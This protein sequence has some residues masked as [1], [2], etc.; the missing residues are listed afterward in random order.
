MKS[1]ITVGLGF[2]D[3]G[4]GTVV[5]AL[6]R[7]YDAKLVIRYNGG[8]QCAHNVVTDDGRHHEFHQFGSGTLVPGCQTLL[9][10]DVLVN[11]LVMF[12]EAKQLEHLGVPNALKRM[13][14]DDRALV[15]TPF[16]RALNRLREYARGEGCHGSCGMGIGET[17]ADA[18]R[19]PHGAL[20][21]GDLL[22]QKIMRE[23]LN[24]TRNEMVALAKQLNLDGRYEDPL[25]ERELST[26]DVPLEEIVEKYN[27][28]SSNVYILDRS[29]VNDLLD[30]TAWAIF[31][32][33]QGVLLDE[34][35]GFHPHTTWSTTTSTNAHS[36]LQE[37]GQ[38]ADL[39]ELGIIRTYSTRHGP[40]PF[41]AYN[42][43]LT[44]KVTTSGEH[45]STGAWQK[46]F[47]CGWL[48]LALM[49][50]ALRLNGTV[51][52]LVVTHVDQLSLYRHWPVTVEYPDV[53]LSPH[54]DLMEQER[55][56]TEPLTGN[57][58]QDRTTVDANEV[59]DLIEA[60]MHATI[61][62][63]SVGATPSHKKFNEKPNILPQPHGH[64]RRD[65]NARTKA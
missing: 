25:I 5:D 14:I 6:V 34:N 31:E 54:N 39:T 44:A 33:A 24:R 11:P 3:E 8:A 37:F 30:E 26:F 16:H 59:L 49:D 23:K 2:G 36:F 42:R 20:R 29:Q 53:D 41:P 1:V 47:R 18:I 9:T 17:M 13:F 51:D 52:G 40:G 50:Y 62:M 4:K 60:T 35:H 57:V 61:L 48:D 46:D 45:N 7:R 27:R 64:H 65:G 63:T 32:G 55:N 28:F 15:T 10:K 38:A 21:I 56:L 58:K 43:D 19:R 22:D 12:T